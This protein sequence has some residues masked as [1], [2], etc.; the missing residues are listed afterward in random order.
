MS[1]SIQLIPEKIHIQR[2]KILAGN[3][4]SDPSI[5]DESVENYNVQYAIDDGFNSESKTFRFV[6]STR[7]DA[8]GKE[9]VDIGISAEYQIEY[10]FYV[11]NLEYYLIR[12][13][14][15]VEQ[16]VI[17]DILIHALL[18]MVYSTSRGII[19]GRTQGTSMDGVILPVID[20]R[21]LMTNLQGNRSPEEAGR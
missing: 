2:I 3:I 8:L 1:E 18:G 6:L 20:T 19:L 16:F 12:D 5:K 17:H 7:I 9:D 4:T 14:D 15:K 10:I 11:E 13:D 21:A